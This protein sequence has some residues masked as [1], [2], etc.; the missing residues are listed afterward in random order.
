MII[1]IIPGYSTY[2]LIITFQKIYQTTQA[3]YNATAIISSDITEIYLAPGEM[4][5]S[6]Y[7]NSPSGIE[8]NDRNKGILVGLIL[9]IILVILVS[10]AAVVLYCTRRTHDFQDKLSH[11]PRLPFPPEARI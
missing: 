11:D 1:G 7:L 10:I 3:F 8:N 4:Q 9:L 5:I 6:G 2:E